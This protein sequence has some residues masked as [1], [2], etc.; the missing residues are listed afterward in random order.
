MSTRSTTV[1]VPDH[2]AGRGGG[3][4]RYFTHHAF[5][6]TDRDPHSP[7][8]QGPSIWERAK[9]LWHS[10]V[11]WLFNV[12]KNDWSRHT[13]DWLQDRLVLLGILAPGVVGGLATQS[14]HGFVA[15]ILWG[16]RRRPPIQPPRQTRTRRRARVVTARR[17]AP[18][19]SL[20]GRQQSEGTTVGGGA[21]FPGG[22]PAR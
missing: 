11:G 18:A 8:P 3:L 21:Y 6:D 22:G 2:G 16:G 4:H 13:R 7:Q 15:G 19:G 1:H 12:M 20:K 14:V 17:P 9:G 10:H 5:A